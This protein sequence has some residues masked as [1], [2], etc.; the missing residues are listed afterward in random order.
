MNYAETLEFLYNKLPMYQRSGKAAYKANLDNT[1]ALDN[2]LGNPHN[3]FRTIHVAGTN[4]KGSVSHMLAAALQQNG[5]KTGLY[6]SPHLLDFRERIRIDGEPIPEQQVTSFV[7][8]AQNIIQQISPSFFE[9]TVAMAFNHFA[10]EKVDIAVIET[11]MGGRLDSTNI[12]TP[13]ISVITNISLDHME[14]LGNS[15]EEIATEKAGIIKAGVPVVIGDACGVSMEV[16]KRI[17]LE[18]K[19]PLVSSGLERKPILT[20][21]S[22]QGKV[23]HRFQNL[24]KNSQEQWET[25]L[26]GE[27]QKYNLITALAVL[28]LL[29]KKGYQLDKDDTSRGLGN[30]SMSTGLRGRWEIMGSNPMLIADTAHNEDGIRAVMEQL[31]NTAAKR[32]H[33]IW[34]MVNDKSSDKIL[35]L[36]PHDADY[37]FTKASIPRALDETDLKNRAHQAKLDGL[38]YPDVKSA[39]E[40]ASRNADAEDVIFIGGSTFVVA[41]ALS[42]LDK[43][44]HSP[45]TATTHPK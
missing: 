24:G 11:G 38:A 8:S 7:A 1:I 9:I 36:L 28:D 18:R 33:I 44:S 5:Y 4:G 2:F 42:C 3:S 26:R 6:T 22:M 16:F 30:I 27:Y 13:E 21:Q 20:T 10:G 32:L 17:T 15:I 25:D 31:S 35:P 37:Y 19:A 12:I 40:A 41:D 39:V 23:T 45:Q 14:F 29:H 43:A 34:G